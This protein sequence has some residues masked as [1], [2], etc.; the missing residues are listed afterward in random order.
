[1]I[2]LKVDI[3]HFMFVLLLSYFFITQGGFDFVFQHQVI[4]FIE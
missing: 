4:E 2:E 1:M 3:H